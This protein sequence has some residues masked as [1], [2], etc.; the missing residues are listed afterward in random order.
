MKCFRCNGFGHHSSQCRTNERQVTSTSHRPGIGGTFHPNHSGHHAS[1]TGRA[2]KQTMC[3]ETTSERDSI[4]HAEGERTDPSTSNMADREREVYLSKW[5]VS[6]VSNSNVKDVIVNKDGLEV[7][8]PV[9]NIIIAEKSV[10]ALIDTGSDV[11]LMS[12]NCYKALNA[13]ECR[14]CSVVMRGIGSNNITSIGRLKVSIT[15]DDNCYN[16]T[17][18]YVVPT[19]CITYDVISGQE[20]LCNI[21]MLMDSGSVLLLPRNEDWLRNM[22]CY[23]PNF[24]FL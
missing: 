2:T 20:F 24:C 6:S 18:F 12:Y 15:I 7:K 19:D 22:T 1:G 21:V 9:K 8:R 11:N 23:V 16:S 4:I 10:C 3:V 5:L 17:E 14:K 13:P